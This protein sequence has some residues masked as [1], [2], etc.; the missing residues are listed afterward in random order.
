MSEETIGYIFVACQVV[1]LLA[2]ILPTTGDDWAIPAW[3]QAVGVALMIGGLV[4]VG[5]GSGKL[6]G[7]LT[8]T[9]VPNGRGELKTDGLYSFVRHPI[10]SGVLLIVAGLVV[11]SGRFIVVAIG[12]ATVSFFFTKAQWEEQRL[13]D[14]FS[15]Y[16]AYAAVT[17]RFVPRLGRLLGSSEKA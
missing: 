4:L 16:D 10:Y 7:A 13:R 2:L 11:R 14:H 6:G 9:P 3:L 12:I 15:D 1:L 5:L 8:A 17:P